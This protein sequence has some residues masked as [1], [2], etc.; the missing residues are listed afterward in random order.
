VYGEEV[1]SVTRPG[2]SAFSNSYAKFVLQ[3]T[4]SQYG[5]IDK[6]GQRV[7]AMQR[8][9]TDTGRVTVYY[10]RFFYISDFYEGKAIVLLADSKDEPYTYLSNDLWLSTKTFE[11]AD[12]YSEGLAGVKIK[13]KWGYMNHDYDIEIRPQF[14]FATPFNEGYAK[15][16]SDKYFGFI[17]KKGDYIIE[18]KYVKTGLLREGVVPAMIGEKWG[19]LD[20][21][22]NWLIQPEYYYLSNSYNGLIA[23]E[24]DGKYGFI[25]RN[26]KVVIY[27]E[28][29]FVE[30]FDAGLAKVWADGELFYIDTKGDR[31][32]TIL[33]KSE[34]N[35]V[36]QDLNRNQ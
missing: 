15:V 17:D 16:M 21:D 32:W 13:G 10:D 4:P 24:K 5:L 18:P 25:D 22:G 30:D 6:Y 2:Y 36:L 1:L 31:I 9:K 8:M 33:D 26:N 14:D 29:D 23:F 34:H 7:S 3:T 19:L 35:S 27:P 28:Y 12:I 11:E 20:K